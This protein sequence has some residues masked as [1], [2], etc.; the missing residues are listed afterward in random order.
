MTRYQIRYRCSLDNGA[1]VMTT[2]CRAP[3]REHAIQRFY[4]CDDQD[5]TIVDVTKIRDSQ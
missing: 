5:W 2:T 1:P 4:D 3:S